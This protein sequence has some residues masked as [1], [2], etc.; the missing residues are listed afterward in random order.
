MDSRFRVDNLLFTRQTLYRLSY[1]DLLRRAASVATR[2]FGTRNTTR[3]VPFTSR[4]TQKFFTI[5]SR[6]NPRRKPIALHSSP[7]S[8]NLGQEHY[9][10]SYRLTGWLCS[11]VGTTRYSPLANVPRRDGRLS[12]RSFHYTSVLVSS[13]RFVNEACLTAPSRLALL[14]QKRRAISG[15]GL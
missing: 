7:W 9:P 13:I 10:F 2:S 12:Q 14:D 6:T 4:V 15:A 8:R 5:P 11:E 1:I 3:H